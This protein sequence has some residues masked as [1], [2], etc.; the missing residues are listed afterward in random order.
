VARATGSASLRE[1]GGS[2]RA[3]EYRVR[4][5]TALPFMTPLCAL[6]ARR[7]REERV[8]TRAAVAPTLTRPD[9][10]GAWMVFFGFTVR[11]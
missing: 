4:P 7:G 1:R 10:D 2:K 6:S 8:K 9:G 3:A 11:T 5:V